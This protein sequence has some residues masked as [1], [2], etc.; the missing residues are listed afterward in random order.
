M[1]FKTTKEHLLLPP[2]HLWHVSFWT[3]DDRLG[4]FIRI[5]RVKYLTSL[6]HE[7]FNMKIMKLFFSSAAMYSIIFYHILS[8]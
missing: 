3:L 4:A 2:A 1:A 7:M 6:D 5:L 8:I